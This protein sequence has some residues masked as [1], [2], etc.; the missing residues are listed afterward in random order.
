MN[1]IR[2]TEKYIN[3]IKQN[4]DFF[5]SYYYHS[6]IDLNLIKLDSI[7]QYGVL[8]KQLIESNKLASIYTHSSSDIDSKNGDTFVSLTEYTD[9]CSFNTMFESFSL[10]TL[11][12]LSLLIN[13]DIN[14]SNEGI[15]ESYFDDEIFCFKS[16][17]K[18]KIEGII[19]AE[20]CRVDRIKISEVN[21]LP[22]DLS[23]YTKSYINHWLKCVENYFKEKIPGTYIEELKIS[24]QQLW[25]I[26][27]H[28]E[29]PEKW[30][31]MIIRKQREKY[32][33]DIKDILANILQY[34]WSL[35]YN[36]ENPKYLD[37]IIKLNKENL[38]VY[39]IKEKCLKK[40]N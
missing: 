12:S 23:C 21:C 11:S 6:L 27:S 35:K 31:E 30:I 3:T 20:K 1:K 32:G 16:I 25:D 39:E 8:S 24:H 13:K 33:K 40:I 15:R 34:F 14:I 19:T 38:S 7:L 5:K 18:S 10:H 2:C 4:N 28:Y 17:D 9:E 22:S 36:L 26:I 37:I 29:S